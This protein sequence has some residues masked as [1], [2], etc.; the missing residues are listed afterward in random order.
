MT[1]AQYRVKA[2]HPRRPGQ[3]L[4]LTDKAGA[5]LAQ[6]GDTCGHLTSAQL[7]SFIRNGYVDRIEAPKKSAAKKAAQ[8]AEGE[9]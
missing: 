6:S 8:A 1:G 3:P 4:R 5:F 9:E 2:E 7:E